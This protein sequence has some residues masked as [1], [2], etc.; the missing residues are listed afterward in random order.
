MATKFRI[1][2]VK[3]NGKMVSTVGA[4][5]LLHDPKQNLKHYPVHI[6]QAI[7]HLMHLSHDVMDCVVGSLNQQLVGT[8]FLTAL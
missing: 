7:T 6:Q 4:R 3:C 8:Y 2:M 5:T 1:D